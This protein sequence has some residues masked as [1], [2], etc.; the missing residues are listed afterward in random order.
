MA[1]AALDGADP[2]PHLL[3]SRILLRRGAPD[4]A[5]TELTRVLALEP[6]GPRADEARALL[7]TLP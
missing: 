7:S 2:R 5:R 4:R 3:L 1:A 6:V